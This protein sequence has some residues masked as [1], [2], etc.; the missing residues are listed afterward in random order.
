MSLPE[1]QRGAGSW[2]QWRTHGHPAALSPGETRRSGNES[3]RDRPDAPATDLLSS[4]FLLM[5]HIIYMPFFPFQTSF[6]L[7]LACCPLAEAPSSLLH[8]LIRQSPWL[9]RVARHLSPKQRETQ[10]EVAKGYRGRQ[11]SRMTCGTEPGPPLIKCPSLSRSA[12]G[13]LVPGPWAA[14]RR[15]TPDKTTLP[16]G[17]QHDAKL[18]AEPSRHGTGSRRDHHV[19]RISRMAKPPPVVEMSL[20][21]TLRV[22]DGC[23]DSTDVL[24][25]LT[26]SWNSGGWKNT[27]VETP[28]HIPPISHL[29]ILT[30]L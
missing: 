1:S 17:H 26:V 10:L 9:K 5:T 2:S 11:P 16:A 23:G 21:S 19:P 27:L 18:T 14:P 6:H 13:L 4:T 8:T 22:P 28:H 12:V 20:L 30:Q 25:G 29:L 24:R 3:R 15:S 7:T